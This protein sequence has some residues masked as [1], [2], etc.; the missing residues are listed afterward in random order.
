MIYGGKR[1]SVIDLIQQIFSSHGNY[2]PCILVHERYLLIQ[3]KHTD[4]KSNCS[5]IVLFIES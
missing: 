5:R 1:Y 4:K 3:L 2:E